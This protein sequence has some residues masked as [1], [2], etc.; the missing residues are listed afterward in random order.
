MK[1][2][3]NFYRFPVRKYEYHKN[4][5]DL[6]GEEWLK[7]LEDLVDNSWKH[8]EKICLYHETFSVSECD[9]ML[10]QEGDKQFYIMAAPT[11]NQPGNGIVYNYLRREN[12]FVAFTYNKNRDIKPVF[13][14]FRFKSIWKD[15]QDQRIKDFASKYTEEQYAACILQSFEIARRHKEERE[16]LQREQVRDAIEIVMEIS[17]ESE[18]QTQVRRLTK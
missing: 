14:E 11:P 3:V 6:N 12:K 17:L 8:A 10:G 5:G 18:Y 4:V 15:F 13:E 1:E 16:Q 9:G 7:Y 2:K